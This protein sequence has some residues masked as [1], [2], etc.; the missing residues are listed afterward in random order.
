MH[1]WSFPPKWK[2]NCN[3]PHSQAERRGEFPGPRFS[4]ALWWT[5][6]LMQSILLL[7]IFTRINMLSLARAAASH[8]AGYLFHLRLVLARP[9]WSWLVARLSFALIFLAFSSL[10]FCSVLFLLIFACRP[11]W[12]FPVPVFPPCFLASPV[13]FLLSFSVFCTDFQFLFCF[14]F[15]LDF[16]R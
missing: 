7:I 6:V 14:C 8:C 11:L 15:V 5:A 13:F 4:G 3:L 9:G 2:L 12:F 10:C 16:L 1:L